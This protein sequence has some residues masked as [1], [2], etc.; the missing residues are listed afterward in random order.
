MEIIPIKYGESF[1]PESA[2]FQNGDEYKKR[3]IVFIVYL[4]KADNR[5]ILV[6]AG[7]ETMP[8]FELKNF[9]GVISALNKNNINPE[10]ITDV[11]I[12]HAHH[13]HIESIKHF[14]NAVVHIEKNEVEEAKKYIPDDFKVNVFDD[15]FSLLDNIHVLKIGGHS[16]G[17]CVVE[18]EGYKRM[19]VIIGDE[20]YSRECITKKIPTG[21]SYCPEKSK[22]FIDKYSSDKYVVLLCHDE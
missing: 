5:L 8:G 2:V 21:W 6:D 3:K 7:C 15:S 18:I 20:C 22:K 1:L 14:N 9:I 17:S 12:T 11:I 4:I 10:M 16:K 13:D 19:Y